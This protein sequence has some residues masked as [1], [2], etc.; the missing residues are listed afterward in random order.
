[1]AIYALVSKIFSTKLRKKYPINSM[2]SL[3]YSLLMRLTFCE[4]MEII[5]PMTAE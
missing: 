5:E 3:P 2:S 4:T 1:M